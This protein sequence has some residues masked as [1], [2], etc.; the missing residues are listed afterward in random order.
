MSH[1]LGTNAFLGSLFL[2]AGVDVYM[3]PVIV[4]LKQ[5]LRWSDTIQIHR[6]KQM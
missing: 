3:I 4:P 5:I 2:T 6:L 1:M